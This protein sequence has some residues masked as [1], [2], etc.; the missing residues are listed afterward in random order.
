MRIF[1]D[2]LHRIKVL[3]RVLPEYFCVFKVTFCHSSVLSL[4]RRRRSEK[5]SGVNFSARRSSSSHHRYSRSEWRTPAGCVCL[6][7]PGGVLRF[8]TSCDSWARSRGRKGRAWPLIPGG[9]EVRVRYGAVQRQ[10]VKAAQGHAGFVGVL[11]RTLQQLTER[12]R[13]AAEKRFT[14]DYPVWSEE[15]AA[16][17]LSDSPQPSSRF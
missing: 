12:R 1:L 13:S 3:H 2:W 9:V 10:E 11:C 15:T 7:E 16:G 17:P 6:E 5:L 14:S 4:H 8:P